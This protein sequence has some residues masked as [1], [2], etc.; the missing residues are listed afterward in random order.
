MSNSTICY[1]SL[2]EY[3]AVQTCCCLIVVHVVIITCV[4]WGA[5]SQTDNANLCIS[6][7]AKEQTNANA[8]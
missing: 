6:Q 7:S 5:L 4:A 2:N 3:Q 8:S 1:Y